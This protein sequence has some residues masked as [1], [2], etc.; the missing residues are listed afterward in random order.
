MA[1]TSFSPPRLTNGAFPFSSTS[2]PDATRAPALSRRSPSTNTSPARMCRAAFSRLSTRPLSTSS[3]SIRTRAGVRFISRSLWATGLA[4]PHEKQ[5]DDPRQEAPDVG[6]PSGSAAR[7]PCRQADRDEPVEELDDDPEAK[8]DGCRPADH[9]DEE[10]E[11]EEH[12][13][14]RVG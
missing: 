13:D 3:R 11:D 8:H 2:A 1:W 12:Q 5:Q 4:G 9:P 10:P 6:K 14:A 7:A